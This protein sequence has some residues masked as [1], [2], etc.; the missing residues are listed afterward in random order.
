MARTQRQN[1]SAALSVPQNTFVLDNGAYTIK[2]GFAPNEL[3]SDNE[4]LKSC[5]TIPNCLVRSKERK[6]YVAAQSNEL[7]QWS[8]AV[9]RRPIENGQLVNWEAE[10]EI[11]DHAFFDQST[12]HR[13]TFISTPSETTLLLTESSN[14][15]PALQRNTDEVIMEEWG[16]RGY[17][18]TTGSS[19]NAYNHLRAL[20]DTAITPDAQPSSTKLPADCLLVVDSG[21]SCTT[22]TPCFQGRPIQRAI[23]RLDFGGKHLTN[24]LKE[25]VSVRHFDLHQDMKIVND[26]KEDI[27]FVSIDF[28]RDLEQAWKGSRRSNKPVQIIPDAMDLGE[29][30]SAKD[31]RIDYVLPD[32]VNLTRGYARPYD[33]SREIANRR[34]LAAAQNIDEI[35]MTL[36]NERFV[37]P[38]IMFNPAD[39]GSKQPGLADAVVQSLSKLPPLIQATMI[40]NVLVVGGTAKIPGFVSRLQDELRTRIR[41]EWPVQ[42]RRMDDPV[43]STWLGG[44]RLASSHQEVMQKMVVTREQYHEYGSAW[45]ARQ[46][47]SVR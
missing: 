45:L 31:T 26:L 16:F 14:V 42:V 23:R 12:A 35:V 44:A 1:N 20:F 40:A 34:K 3:L 41:T 46:F 47:A 32:G 28:K 9:F 25:I 29:D 10:K 8:E 6:T 7:S 11:W 2:A 33:P 24:Y 37:V 30:E 18:R 39:I 15:M 5:E 22:I 38:E 13:N 17:M 36:G 43:T 21:Y 19:L 27:S 4:S